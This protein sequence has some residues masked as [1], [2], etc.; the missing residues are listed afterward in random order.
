MAMQYNAPPSI[1]S[2]IGSQI[3]L[4]YY[5]RKALIEAAQEQYFSMLADTTTMPKNMGKTIKSYVYVPLLHDANINTQG[6]DPS[7][8]TIDTTKYYISLGQTTQQYAVE[9]DAT[10][11]TNAINAIQA[12]VAVKS[13]SSTPW[14]VTVSTIELIGTTNSLANAAVAASR[15]ATK[16]QGSGNFYGSSKDIGTIVGKLPVLDETG[17]R[18][19]RVGFTRKEL[20]GTFENFGFFYE[21]SKDSLQFDTDA[22]LQMHLQRELINGAN[23]MNEDMLQI[24]LINAAG[25]VKLAG[26]KTATYLMAAG[27]VVSYADLIQLGIDLDNNRCPKQTKVITGSQMTDTKVV[28]GGRIMYVGSELVPTLMRMK[29]FHEQPAFIDVKHYAAGSTPL[30]GEIGSV[31]SFRIIQV[32]KMLHWDNAGATASDSTYYATGG[33]YNVYPMLVIGSE[34]FTTIGFQTDGKN[35]KF[36]TITKKPSEDTADRNDP[37]GKL[38]FS[39]IEWYYGFLTQRMERIALIKTL[40]KM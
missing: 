1:P 2:T 26:G 21:W 35:L 9:A 12:G 30:R 38:G 11:A 28:G 24:D 33:R 5:Q 10:A 31:A 40:G 20:S 17:G 18:V 13:G 25:V 29:D 6:I 27:D 3:N 4:H 14:T 37:Y 22:D 16:R 39:S 19:N 34:S 23:E 32:P 8:V 15:G 36:K 7:G